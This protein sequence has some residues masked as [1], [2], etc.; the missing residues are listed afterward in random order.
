[1]HDHG[2]N[3]HKKTKKPV[4]LGG[5]TEEEDEAI[6]GYLKNKEEKKIDYSHH[7]KFRN[8]FQNEDSVG[9]PNNSNSI[10]IVRC[11]CPITNNFCQLLGFCI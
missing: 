4:K 10:A 7:Y 3:T 11:Y 6:D 9:L 5:E 1:M 8:T 2:S